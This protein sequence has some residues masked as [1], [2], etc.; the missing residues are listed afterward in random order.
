[1]LPLSV[2][3]VPVGCAKLSEGTE[4][5]QDEWDVAV[6]AILQFKPFGAVGDC[7]EDQKAVVSTCRGEGL[8]MKEV[9][10][11]V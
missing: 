4:T 9:G 7:E 10:H 3:E 5:H 6:F 1:V 11:L 8:T 2:H